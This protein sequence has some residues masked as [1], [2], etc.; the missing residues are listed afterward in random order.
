MENN[1]TRPFD[2][3]SFKKQLRDLNRRFPFLRVESVGKSVMGKELLAL[4][5]VK[6]EKYSLI[7]G[8]L[9]GRSAGS[10]ELLVRFTEEL[11]SAFAE[12][13][14]ISRFR[15]R[16]VLVGKGVIILPCLNPDGC[17]LASLGKSACGDREEFLCSLSK[18][19]FESFPYNARGRR[20]DA[21][22]ACGNLREPEAAALDRLIRGLDLRHLLIVGHGND[23]LIVPRSDP[24]S[25]R[26]AE[27]LDLSPFPPSR[28]DAS[29][30]GVAKRLN[31]ELS[32]PAGELLLSR[33]TLDAPDEIYPAL[34]EL[35]MLTI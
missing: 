33:N 20:L 17:E 22:L 4:A 26:L 10:A 31:E 27:L 7:V 35:L 8:G 25:E 12:D 16:R 28:E 9:D 11:C 30:L 24:H 23:E 6:A 3:I 2:F 29:G 14:V 34:C 1:K 15:V 18:G 13:K 32:L 5:P 19:N 21:E